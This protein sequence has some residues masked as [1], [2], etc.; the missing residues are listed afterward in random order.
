[1]STI[2]FEPLAHL[3]KPVDVDVHVAAPELGG[4]QD[5]ARTFANA[6]KACRVHGLSSST[7]SNIIDR[8][9][10]RLQQF[11]NEHACVSL[12]FAVL[13]DALCYKGHTVL[14]LPPGSDP[15][16]TAMIRSGLRQFAFLDAISREELGELIELFVGCQPD[17]DHYDISTLLWER[18]FDQIS[19]LVVESF[20]DDLGSPRFQEQLSELLSAVAAEV[21]VDTVR[22][23]RFSE[24][25]LRVKAGQDAGIDTS[26]SAEDV[27]DVS[28]EEEK[29]S[30]I[31]AKREDVAVGARLVNILLRLAHE[32]T[33]DAEREL[34]ELRLSSLLDEELQFGRLVSVDRALT[35]LRE[36]GARGKGTRAGQT[37]NSVIQRLVQAKAL[38]KM[39][40]AAS[41]SNEAA[42]TVASIL[43]TLGPETLPIAYGIL[44]ALVTPAS[45]TAVCAAMIQMAKKDPSTLI[46]QLSSSPGDSWEVCVPILAACGHPESGSALVEAYKWGKSDVKRVIVRSLAKRR[47]PFVRSLL[48]LS[49]SSEDAVLRMLAYRQLSEFQEGGTD[50]RAADALFAAGEKDILEAHHSRKEF[51]EILIALLKCSADRALQVMQRVVA[52]AE[53]QSPEL[54]IALAR[55]LGAVR[56]A[57]AQALLSTLARLPSDE[58][59]KECHLAMRRTAHA[60]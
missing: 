48:I 57:N 17:S 35:L 10:L 20:A 27:F 36:A 45:K 40:N 32:S 13:P 33:D 38:G 52:Q 24:D 59:A 28:Q 41:R 54:L 30:E 18:G 34:F 53:R 29:I 51:Q 9:H 25:D 7:A 50:R 39:G 47:E 42:K 2:D 46:R 11:F 6:L 56:S 4:A 58:L 12:P 49:L 8:L 44:R 5:V 19:Y 23:A 3:A 1:M 60:V 26:P 37:A 22:A 55:V 43:E 14:E 21:P 15:A 31:L 16:F